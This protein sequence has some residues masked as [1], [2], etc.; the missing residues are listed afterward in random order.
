MLYDVAWLKYGDHYF[1]LKVS[2][3]GLLSINNRFPPPPQRRKNRPPI[4]VLLTVYPSNPT[5]HRSTLARAIH[6][7]Y[8][9]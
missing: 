1:F 2:A 5:V 7:N 6:P 8:C 3:Y 9:T 4:G